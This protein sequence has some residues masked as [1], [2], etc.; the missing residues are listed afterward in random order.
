[1]NLNN[2][3]AIKSRLID[4]YNEEL[5]NLNIFILNKEDIRNNR[6]LNNLFLNRISEEFNC[7]DK[8]DIRTL[9]FFYA[10]SFIL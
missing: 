8:E 10:F 2:P 3:K 1:M 5:L 7:L 6:D 9:S 4:I